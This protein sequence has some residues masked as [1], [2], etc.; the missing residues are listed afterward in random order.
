MMLVLVAIVTAALG[1]HI[2]LFD[3]SLAAE[4]P[5][6]TRIFVLNSPSSRSAGS[7]AIVTFDTSGKG[8]IF[9]GSQNRV[10]GARD[11]VCSPIK[12]MDCSAPAKPSMCP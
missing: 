7:D 4:P 12:P 8:G 6:V 2:F 11:L 9:F 5:P 1:C 10:E 3:D